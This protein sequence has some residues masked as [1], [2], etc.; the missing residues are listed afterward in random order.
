M[1][2]IFHFNKAFLPCAAVSM[3]IILSFI[4]AVLIRGINQSIEFKPGII[5]E[6]RITPSVSSDSVRKALADI[7]GTDV[8]QIG[9]PEDGLFQIRAG[10]QE[11]KNAT[12]S[13]LKFANI[14]LLKTFGMDSVQ[15]IKT[16]FIGA[17][18][19]SSLIRNTVF[20][21]SAT[22]LLIWLY[23]TIRFRWD[24]ALGAIIALI[25][26]SLI[27]LS[28]IAWSGIEFSTTTIAAILTIIGYSINATVVILDRVREN[29]NLYPQKGIAEIFNMALTETM[30]RSLITTITTM[31]ASISLYIF[32]TGSIKDFAEVLNI[33]LISGCYSSI[34]ISSGFIVFLRS[35]KPVE[36]IENNEQSGIETYSPLISG[37]RTK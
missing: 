20:L 22:F 3:L 12:Q 26:D 37:G 32:T 31:M 24:F 15:V 21:V 10:I 19:S 27:M 7:K 11:K 28:Y 13:L 34:F 6:V 2:K 30:S 14:K 36:K 29:S 17:Q 25:H 5:E 9:D 16:D 33:G 18:Y 35:L 23:A 8:K 1:K 4:P